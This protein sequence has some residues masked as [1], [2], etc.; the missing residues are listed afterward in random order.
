VNA[1]LGANLL[2]KAANFF[3]EVLLN[4]SEF[5]PNWL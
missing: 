4:N 5:F 3:F 1:D 2:R